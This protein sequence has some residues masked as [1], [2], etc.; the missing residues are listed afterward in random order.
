MQGNWVL[1]R[2]SWIGEKNKIKNYWLYNIFLNIYN[3]NFKY[4]SGRVK[5]GGFVIIMTWTQLDPLLKKFS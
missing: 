5:L 2:K 1:Y 4:I 3:L